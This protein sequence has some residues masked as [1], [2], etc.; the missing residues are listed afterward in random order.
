MCSYNVSVFFVCFW[1]RG[2]VLWETEKNVMYNWS[3]TTKLTRNSPKQKTDKYTLRR[4]QTSQWGFVFKKYITA[5]VME[6]KKLSLPRAH[7]YMILLYVPDGSLGNL[8][9][10]ECSSLACWWGISDRKE[11]FIE[12]NFIIFLMAASLTLN[13]VYHCVI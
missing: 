11:I 8:L 10:M 4:R 3:K 1:R 13:F 12:I 5:D 2:T 7:L 6:H 9:M